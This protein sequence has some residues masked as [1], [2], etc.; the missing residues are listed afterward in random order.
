VE[1]FKD[2]SSINLRAA[3]YL[4]SSWGRRWYL[5]SSWGRSRGRDR[6]PMTPVKVK[7][8]RV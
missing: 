2:F 8:E 4:F 1:S 6:V 5:S 7:M 3:V